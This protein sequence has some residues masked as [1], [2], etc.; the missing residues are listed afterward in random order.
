MPGVGSCCVIRS[1][2]IALYKAACNGTIWHCKHNARLSTRDL[3]TGVIE[4]IFLQQD[5][6]TYIALRQSLDP[7]VLLHHTTNSAEISVVQALTEVQGTRS[8]VSAKVTLLMVCVCVP[9]S[10][11]TS[12]H[13]VLLDFRNVMY[14]RAFGSILCAVEVDSVGVCLIQTCWP[15]LENKRVPMAIRGLVGSSRKNTTTSRCGSLTS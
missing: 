5:C 6:W 12:T 11:M 13:H 14:D 3:R 7:R 8:C 1:F 9:T 2:S 15:I 4:K 10:N